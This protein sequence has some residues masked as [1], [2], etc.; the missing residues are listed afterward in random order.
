MMI[1]VI[2]QA[3]HLK[4]SKSFLS[5]VPWCWP[6]VKKRKLHVFK[7]ARFRKEMEILENE[8][9][10][11]VPDSASLLRGREATSNPSRR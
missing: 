3:H 4:S 2:G 5:T 9:N 11:F 1:R 7:G 6:P 8:A 10:L